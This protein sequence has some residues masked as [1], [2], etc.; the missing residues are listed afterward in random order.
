M[1]R[2]SQSTELPLTLNSQARASLPAQLADQLRTH[3]TS[4]TLQPADGL[5]STRVL[6]TRLGVA[7]GTIVA[8]YEQLVSEGYLSTS[9]AGTRVVPE[10]PAAIIQDALTPTPPRNPRPTINSAP[11]AG[12]D[13]RPGI[14]DT[15]VVASAAWRAA[16]R[17]A[18]AE[19][20]L[21]HPAQGSPRLQE[22][23]AHHLRTM[24]HVVCNPTEILVTAGARDGFR[25]LLSA[26]R[27]QRHERPLHIA[28]E[29]PGYPSLYQIPAVFGHKIIPIEVDQA[30]LNP[31]ALP[32]NPAPDIVL[33][34]PSHQ[35]PLGASMPVARRLELLDWARRH[36]A[37]IVEDDYDSELRYV[38][39]ALPALT[40]LSRQQDHNR[41]IMLGSF[42]KTLTPALGL[43]FMLAPPAITQEIQALR[44]VLGSPV[45]AMTQ[46]A[47]AQ[48]LTD[49][50]AHRHIARMRRIY[51]KRRELLMHALTHSKLP[52]WVT[53]LP[54]D[55]GLHLV[56]KFTGTQATAHTEKTALTT[57]HNHGIHLAALGDYWAHASLRPRRTYGLVL[58]F[59]GTSQRH[60]TQAAHTI[61]QALHSL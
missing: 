13:M 38:G 41:T 5:P 25:L 55:G 53:I 42:T 54:M 27:R 48:F 60:I 4:G 36:K 1:P 37:Y 15:S 35:Y 56:L 8:A 24:R 26:L 47:A 22:Q 30:G 11:T 19:P 51:K 40:A 59:G 33:V 9:K 6:A 43:G 39:D 49:G 58:G 45:S 57:I 10:L 20:H 3:I 31:A 21:T 7:R 16:W 50:G 2:Y 52:N 34:A 61:A 23:L 17:S 46:D 14:P 28:V 18:A 44:D 32:T 29:N 12:I